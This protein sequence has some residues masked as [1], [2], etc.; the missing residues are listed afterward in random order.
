M[1]AKA[2]AVYSY[3]GVDTKELTTLDFLKM[4]CE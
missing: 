3:R 4:F 2:R 1:I